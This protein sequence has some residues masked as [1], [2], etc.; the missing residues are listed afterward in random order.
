MLFLLRISE[1]EGK[2]KT[3]KRDFVCVCA[4]LE[5]TPLQSKKAEN[6][7]NVVNR[8]SASNNKTIMGKQKAKQEC[9]REETTLGQTLH[10]W[11]RALV[12]NNKKNRCQSSQPC[13][14]IA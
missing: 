9:E 1:V 2:T 7:I 6:V 13:T 10:R 5:N 12:L 8:S 4:C 11:C 14:R 3:R